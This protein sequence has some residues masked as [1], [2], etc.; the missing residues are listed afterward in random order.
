LIRDLGAERTVILSTHILSEVSSVCDR[1]II[2]HQGRILASES[3]VALRAQLHR[4]RVVRVEAEGPEAQLRAVLERLPGVETVRR[5]EVKVRRPEDNGTVA[6]IV[7]YA[8]DDIRRQV[9]RAV[10][11]NGWGLLE[12]RSLE[13]TLEDMYLQLIRDEEQALKIELLKN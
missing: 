1:V 9:S 12:V 13:P 11:E 7:E 10:M 2:I 3:L 6:L 4:T 5:P 8:G